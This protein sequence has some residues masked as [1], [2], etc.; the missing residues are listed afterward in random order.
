MA[1]KSNAQHALASLDHGA[2]REE[3]KAVD[4]EIENSLKQILT[5]LLTQSEN[6][7]QK[8]IRG[9]EMQVQE[10]QKV[11]DG[12]LTM[13]DDAQSHTHAQQLSTKKVLAQRA[14]KLQKEF[15]ASV[16]LPSE[17]VRFITDISDPAII[18]KIISLGCVSG[19]G[20]A[21][22]TLGMFLVEFWAS[23]ILSRW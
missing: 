14:T 17:M 16:L 5:A 3:K 7:C 4:S 23:L 8:K 10:L 20:I 9:L 1:S 21:C 19:G 11:R 12:M 18:S 15:E 22:A 13:I 6:I 2:G